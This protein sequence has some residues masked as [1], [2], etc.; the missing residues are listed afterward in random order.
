MDILKKILNVLGILV[1]IPLSMVLVIMLIMTPVMSAATSFMQ[2]ENLQSVVEE[3]DFGE[4]LLAGGELE[5][6]FEEGDAEAEMIAALMNSRTV[7]EV[8]SLYVDGVLDVITGEADD[9][10]ITAETFKSVAEENLDEWVEI[11]TPYLET[12]V[13]LPQEELENLA[14][15]M[16]DE[17]SGSMADAFP[18]ADEI[19]LDAELRETIAMLRNGAILKGLIVMVVVLSVLILL[20]RVVRFEGFMWLGVVYFLGAAVSLAVTQ[21][22]RGVMVMM[23]TEAAGGVEAIA[24]PLMS[25]LITEMYKGTGVLA[26]LAVVFI[27]V[28]IVGRIILKKRNEVQEEVTTGYYV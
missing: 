25:V 5:G 27:A 8:L 7:K 1:A 22:S 14:R 15:Q 26:V 17:L 9:V 24:E 23:L 6:S 3:I 13:E 16:I 12:D 19:G 11:M 4:L 10:G 2:T 28:F 18:S 21:G 20:F